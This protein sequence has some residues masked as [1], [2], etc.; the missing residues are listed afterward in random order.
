M[1]CS[2]PVLPEYGDQ[3]SRNAGHADT[4]VVVHASAASAERPEGTVF[5]CPKGWYDAG[6]YNLYIVNAGI[7]TYTLL[8]AYE[9]FPELHNNLSTNIPESGNSIPDIL[10]EVKWNLD[11][12]LSMQDP[13]DGGVYHKLSNLSFDGITTPENGQDNP[14]YVFQKST[15]AALNLAAVAATAARVFEPFDSDYAAQCLSAA[16]LAYEWANNNPDVNYNQAEHNA[17]YDPDTFTGEYGGTILPAEFIWASAELYITTLNDDYYNSID[18]LSIGWYPIPNWVNVSMLPIYSLMLHQADLTV[19]A[20]EDL[21]FLQSRITKRA[22]E[23]V[24][25]YYNN[26]AHRVTLGVNEFDFIWGSN[27]QAGNQGMLLTKAFHLTDNFAYLNAAISCFDYI[28]GRNATEYCMITGLGD[29]SS[30]Q[31][32][33]RPSEADDVETSVPGLVVGGPQNQFNPDD[34]PY[35]FNSPAK[36]Y[37][38]DWCSYST[39]EIA[40]NWNAPFVFLASALQDNFIFGNYSDLNPAPNSPVASAEGMLYEV[41][42]LTWEDL[43]SDEHN[44]LVYRSNEMNPTP[45]LLSSLAPNASTY[46]DVDAEY[47]NVYRYE[48]FAENFNGISTATL[49]SELFVNLQEVSIIDAGSSFSFPDGTSLDNITCDLVYNSLFT[50]QAGLDSLVVTTITTGPNTGTDTV[51]ACESFTWIDGVTYTENNSEATLNI[52]EGSAA[53][54]DSLVTLNLTFLTPNTNFT[55][56]NGILTS[57]SPDAEY[58]WIDCDNGNEPIEG[59]TD[60]SYLVTSVGNYALEITENGC[61]SS[62][63]CI[64][65][66]T[67]GI[68][69]T[70]FDSAFQL[71]PNPSNGEVTLEF[72]QAQELV[73]ITLYDLIGRVILT[74]THNN[75]QTLQLTL[76]EPSGIYFL[77]VSAGDKKSVVRVI[78]EGE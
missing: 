78:I 31:P 39:N 10:D 1:R 47:G 4:E 70:S 8:A 13:N 61:S 74:Q 27:S 2:S 24:N 72:G 45:V 34:C 14:R 73:Q 33:H 48:I 17:T 21:L 7:S 20:Q 5:S 11:W 38:D 36:N 35:E 22:D 43:A 68:Q 62:S 51:E 28:L 41:I 29:F 53:G 65:V 3:W 64:E 60:Q 18:W 58:Q 40:I 66:L 25:H 23:L 49:E 6:D 12:M 50:S 52:I 16:T 77:T 19:I 67:V 44:Y 26:S 76:N 54:C 42:D 55:S 59:A 9:E 63:E 30:N 56:S 37:F 57:D 71:Y 46:T 32:H 69:N 15:S 75:S